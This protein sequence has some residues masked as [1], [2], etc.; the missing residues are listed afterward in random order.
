[1]NGE[2][3]DAWIKNEQ[4]TKKAQEAQEQISFCASCAFSWLISLPDR[5]EFSFGVFA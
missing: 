5:L 2:A 3:P 4:A 1:M